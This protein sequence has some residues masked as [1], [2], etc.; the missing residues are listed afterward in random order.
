MRMTLNMRVTLVE[1]IVFISFV[2]RRIMRSMKTRIKMTM[3]KKLNFEKLTNDAEFG[4]NPNRKV[5]FV[6]ARQTIC[7]CNQYLYMYFYMYL[8]QCFGMYW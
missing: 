7:I 1:S 3:M 4:S 6:N 8:Y 2:M 5:H